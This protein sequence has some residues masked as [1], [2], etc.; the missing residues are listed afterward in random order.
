MSSSW[1]FFSKENVFHEHQV[2]EPD[3]KT[4]KP[5]LGKILER[6]LHPM[7]QQ[8]FLEVK[9]DESIRPMQNDLSEPADWVLV[10]NTTNNSTLVSSKE[11]ISLTG[12]HISA[13]RGAFEGL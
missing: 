12:I 5:S 2:A 4:S 10:F 13:W 7:L 8:R 6:V 9:S 11:Y 1:I 3:T